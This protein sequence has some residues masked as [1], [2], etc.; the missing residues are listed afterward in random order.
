MGGINT[1]VLLRRQTP[2][3]RAISKIYFKT[4]AEIPPVSAKIKGS[5]RQLIL[6]YLGK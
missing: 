3:Q 6:Q 2:D 1:S 4:K 5:L